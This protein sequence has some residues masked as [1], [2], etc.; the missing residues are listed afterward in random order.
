MLVT[1]LF[2]F[3][4]EIHHVTEYEPANKAI[5]K[6]KMTRESGKVNGFIYSNCSL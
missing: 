1:C 4:L 3:F 6:V 2:F 5:K